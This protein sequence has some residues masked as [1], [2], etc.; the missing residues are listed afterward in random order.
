MST[1]GATVNP[2]LTSHSLARPTARQLEIA[3]I[4]RDFEISRRGASAAADP[5]AGRPSLTGGRMTPL[6][7]HLPTARPSGAAP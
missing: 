5:A 4:T 2:H 6:T 1:V 3:R 7:Q